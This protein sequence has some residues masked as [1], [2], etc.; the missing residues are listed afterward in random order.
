MDVNFNTKLFGKKLINL[1]SISSTNDYLKESIQN[2]PSG[3]VVFASEQ[4]AGKGAKGHVWETIKG[5]S[6]AASLL[7]KDVSIKHLPMMPLIFAMVGVNMFNALGIMNAK[8][9]WIN[10]ILIGEKKVAGML[11]ESII[12][13]D[14]ID[15]VFGAGINVS[16]TNGDF[17]RL[18]LDYAGSL[19]TQTNKLFSLDYVKKVFVETFE[20]TFFGYFQ[21]ENLKEK[22][23]KDYTSKSFTLGRTVKI[24]K[25]SEQIIA[26]AKAVSSDG[27]LIC[28]YNGETIKVYHSEAS[29][30][31]L[32]GYI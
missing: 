6:V 32:N 5:K 17:E 24:I 10:D 11:C 15:V 20:K 27:A 12:Q 26:V 18:N 22:V 30:R 21:S 23:I 9:K 16:C 14:Y 29:V 13:G 2:L 8:I 1:E 7:V 4:T 3:T 31:G 25:N 28:D 19:F